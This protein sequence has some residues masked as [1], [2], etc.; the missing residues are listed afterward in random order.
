MW[1]VKACLQHVGRESSFI[2]RELRGSEASI[3]LPLA[4]VAVV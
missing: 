1:A 4:Q 2:P 3:T